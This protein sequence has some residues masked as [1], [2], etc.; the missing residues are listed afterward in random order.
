[1]DI[2]DLSAAVTVVS[3]IAFVG[4]CWWALSSRRT[5][6]FAQAARLAVDDDLPIETTKTHGA[7]DE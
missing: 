7:S 3:F 1:M 2:N 5:A 4:I 6:D